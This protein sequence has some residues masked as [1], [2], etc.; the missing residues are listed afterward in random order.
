MRYKLF[1]FLEI[2]LA[3]YFKVLLDKER[4]QKQYK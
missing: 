4:L 2:F 1:S 3:S